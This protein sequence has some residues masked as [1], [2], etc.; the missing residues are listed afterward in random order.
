MPARMISYKTALAR[1]Q[2]GFDN[3]SRECANK[4]LAFFKELMICTVE[5]TIRDNMQCIL[6]ANDFY[7]RD[8][9]RDNTKRMMIKQ[10]EE[11]INIDKFLKL[12]RKA[13]YN[14]LNIEDY[15]SCRKFYINEK[16]LNKYKSHIPK[17]W[18]IY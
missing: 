2:K 11:I 4:T 14:A 15:G 6:T 13:N 3:K 18:D 5:D 9:N 16:M 10:K 12:L 8:P 1:V 7:S 17:Y